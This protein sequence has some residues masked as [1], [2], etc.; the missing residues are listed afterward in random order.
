[1]P[2]TGLSCESRRRAGLSLLLLALIAS[3]WVSERADPAFF[4]GPAVRRI[5]SG[6][7]AL[8]APWAGPLDATAMNWQSAAGYRY[9][10]PEGYAI[11]PG[12]GD[13]VA[14][15]PP[16]SP[17]S[18]V[19]KMIELN[20]SVPARNEALRRSMACDLVHWQVRTVV[21]GP[22]NHEDEAVATMAWVIGQVPEYVQGVWVWWDVSP[23]CARL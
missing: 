13:G 10:M 23:T 2:S 14:F 15:D 17:T 4:S 20:D 21:V 22:M 19:L 3:P 9:R 12:P 6:S 8:V 5:P 18:N 7:V 16:P 1:L 11:V